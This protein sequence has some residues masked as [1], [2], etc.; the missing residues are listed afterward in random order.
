MTKEQREIRNVLL[1]KTVPG[2]DGRLTVMAQGEFRIPLG[3]GDGAD[4]VRLFGM[5]R[6]VTAYE[7]KWKEKK[8]LAAAA[9]SMRN[10]GRGLSLREQPKAAA[11]LIRYVFGRPA[12]LVFR[13]QEGIPVLTAWAGRGLA[14]WLSLRR[15]VSDFER[16]LPEEGEKYTE[17]KKE[18][19]F[20]GWLR[21]RRE[22]KEAA[23]ETPE[24]RENGESG[25]YSE[26]GEEAEYS[27]DG[28]YGEENE[29]GKEAPRD[30]GKGT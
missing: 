9:E 11:C 27:E 8:T 6:R 20:A 15:A 7:S 28:E 26:Y 18:S 22:A 21:R 3:V 29:Y 24:D 13:Y 1:G 17:P 16:G 4:A 14:G 23:E 12:V 30:T 10:I 2:E 19:A 25:E 5:T